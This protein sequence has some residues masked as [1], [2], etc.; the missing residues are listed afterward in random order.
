MKSSL[1]I[2]LL[3]FFSTL[4]VRSQEWKKIDSVDFKV[5]VDQVS[6]DRQ[7]NIYISNVEGAIE[8]YDRNG[9]LKRHFS[10]NKKSKSS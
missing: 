3:I 6:I 5:A 4:S 9:I 10:S 8:K 2:S 7:G 1:A